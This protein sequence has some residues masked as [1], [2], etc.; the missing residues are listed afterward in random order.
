V[1][2]QEEES[3]TPQVSHA[4][5]G[6]SFWRDEVTVEEADGIIRRSFFCNWYVLFSY[7]YPLGRGMRRTK[8]R[9]NH[10]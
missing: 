8:K 2:N 6:L 3:A 4:D 7:P 9:N 10:S 5:A 1:T